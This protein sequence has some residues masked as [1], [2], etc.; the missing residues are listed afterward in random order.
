MQQNAGI[1]LKKLD[2]IR[3]N[4]KHTRPFNYNLNS[5]SFYQLQKFIE[6]KEKLNGIP[7]TYVEPENKSKECS[8][9][10]NIGIR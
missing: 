7:I 9:C 3:N 2:G 10:G 1:K 6:Y 4:R 8:R 5:W